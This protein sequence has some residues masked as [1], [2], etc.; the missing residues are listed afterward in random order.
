MLHGGRKL[1][2]KKVI[3]IESICLSLPRPTECVAWMDTVRAALVGTPDARARSRRSAR[4]R[5][6]PLSSM[7]CVWATPARYHVDKG[8]QAPER[9]ELRPR[10]QVSLFV[11]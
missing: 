2:Y 8:K 5:L 3:I 10:N 4:R 1:R 7:A 11:L 6:A 9:T